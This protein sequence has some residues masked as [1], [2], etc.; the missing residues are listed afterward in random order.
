LQYL[1]A[2]CHTEYSNIRLLDSINKVTNMIDY[3][4]K[5][6]YKGIAITDHACLSGHI[7]AIKHVKEQKEKGNIPEDFK[8]ILGEEIYL[9]DNIEKYKEEYDKEI[10]KYFHFILLAKDKIGHQ[11][12]RKISSQAWENAFNQR[13]M[14]RVP[15]TYKEIEDIIKDNPGHLIGSTACLGS[16]FAQ[17]ILNK[18]KD[19]V[20]NILAWGQQTFGK[21]NFFIE[22]QPSI[23]TPEQQLYNL[24]AYEYAK[25]Y[26]IPII[27]TTDAHYLTK[28]DREIHKAY[29]NS[30]EGEREVDAF[31]GSTYLMTTDDIQEYLEH[32][33]FSKDDIHKIITNSMKIYDLCEEYDLYHEPIVPTFTLPSF[34]LHDLFVTQYET[35]EY[36]KKFGLSENKQDKY[37]LFQIEEGMIEKYDSRGLT[38][39]ETELKR[40]NIE[41]GEIWKISEV[42]NETVSA[43]YNTMKK[44]ID[45][46]WEDGDSIVGP[47]RGSITGYYIAYLINI[48]QVNPITWE[49]PY[50]R[51]LTADRPELPD[52]D[53]DTE[54]MKRR[55]ILEAIKDYFGEDSVINIS[56]FGTESSKS[57]I[58]TAC[59]GLGIDVD[60][61][62]YMASM[63]PVERGFNWNI[64]DCLNGNEE[65]DRKPVKKLITE[66]KKYPKLIDTVLRIEG[67][68]NKRSI[69]ASGVYIFN[70]KYTNFNAGMKAPNGQLITQFNMNDSDYQGGLKFDLLTVQAL[71]K[72]RLTLNFLLE[73][74]VIEDKGH[75]LK[76]Y[77]TYLHPDVLDYKTLDMWKMIGDNDIIDLFQF[78]TDIGLAA[79]KLVKPTN[80]FELATANSLMRLMGGK[81]KQPL[82]EYREYKNNIDLWYEE[83]RLC[84]LT[85]TEIEILE[86]HLKHLYGVADTQEVVMEMAMNPKIANFNLTEANKLRKAIGKKSEKVM[87]ESRKEFFAKGLAAGTSQKLL[88]YVWNVQISRQL[89]YNTMPRYTAMYNL[90]HGEPINIGCVA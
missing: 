76:N 72:I 9:I 73:D 71:D 65:K 78:E 77:K 25:T 29:L 64:N 12:L 41:L 85:T 80:L 17:Q 44:I 62:L 18:N 39:G 55:N 57:A 54:A 74:K 20:D 66:M 43:Y 79:A 22:I 45:I 19:G 11:Q 16:Y 27:V 36:I 84:N 59:R 82:D 47:A 67:L 28:E 53:V 38:Y 26:D 30:K 42:L 63:I 34:K 90:T 70:D 75:L 52:I 56:T 83:M 8:L 58:L 15:I 24:K 32:N 37:L 48:T 87:K 69:H 2:H 51:H 40:I 13:R 5:I 60:S 35:Y 23:E 14:D 49:L 3:A 4:V 10:M 31:Y 7:K 68:V 88:D 89:G 81:D 86:F 33:G 1:N 50:W 21:E 46:M 6:D 61:G